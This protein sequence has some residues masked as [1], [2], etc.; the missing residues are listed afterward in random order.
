MPDLPTRATYFKIGADEILRRSDLRP[1]GTRI[2]PE[3]IYEDGSDANILV[4]SS[5][6]MAD[7]ATRQLSQRISALFLDGAF[8]EELDRLVADRFSPTIVRKAAS[9]AIGV[10]Q[11]T[12]SAGTF[13]AASI[14][15]GSK[16][17]TASGVEFT[18]LTSAVLPLGSTGPVSANVQAVNAGVAGNVSI[19]SVVQFVDQPSDNSIQVNNAEPMSGGAEKE[20]DASLRS[21]ARDFFRTARRGTLAAIEFGALAVPGVVQATAVEEVDSL[22]IPTGKVVLYIADSLGQANAA[23]VAAVVTSLVEYRAAGVQVTT[24]GATPTYVSIVLN[25]S[26][27]AGVDSTIAFSLVRA[28]VVAAV[29]NLS[30]NDTLRVSLL[31][32]TIRSVDGVIVNDDAIVAPVGDLVPAAGQVIRTTESLVTAL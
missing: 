27:R 21:R 11:F 31:F 25:L 3:V 29:N 9:P 5:S 7:E 22:N 18:L 10:V 8:D 20:T 30:P 19:M 1:V 6:A 28:A 15:I 17:R 12:R 14:P 26:F 13:P 4:A 2:T 23:L 32:A 16:V 24:I